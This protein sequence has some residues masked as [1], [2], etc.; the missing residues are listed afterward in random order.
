MCTESTEDSIY[1]LS[2]TRHA[3]C[4]L[5]EQFSVIWLLL[6]PSMHVYRPEDNPPPIPFQQMVVHGGVLESTPPDSLP[7]TVY[8]A[9]VLF[10]HYRCEP[11]ELALRSGQVRCAV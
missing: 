11:D 3:L 9:K 8:Y 2:P 5:F 7:P 10:S 4:V 1:M 6:C